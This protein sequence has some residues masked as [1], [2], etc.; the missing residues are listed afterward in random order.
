MKDVA[1]QGIYRIVYDMVRSDYLITEDEIDFMDSICEE[2]S[3]TSELR[4]SALNMS[5]ADAARE[6]KS[7]SNKQLSQF[8]KQLDQLTLKDGTCYREEALLLMGLAL[9]MDMHDKAEI[10]SVPWG[11]IML[12]NNQVLFVENG[13][14]EDVN[15]YITEHYMHIVN[16][17][18]I[19]GFEFVYVPKVIEQLC[20]TGTNLLEKVVSHLAPRKTKE[21]TDAI[22]SSIQGQTT[23]KVYR[24]LLL[25]KLKFNIDINEPSILIRIGLSFVNGKRMSNYVVVKLEEKAATQIDLL[26]DHFLSMQKSPT[27]TIR[28]NSIT[29]DAFVYNGFYRVLFDLI[30]YRK[31]VRCDLNIYPYNHKNV[32][33]ITTKSTEGEQEVPLEI[34]PKECAFYIFLIYETINYGGFNLTCNTALDIKY[35]D[36]AQKRFEKIYFDLCNRDVAPDITNPEIRRPMLSKIKKAVENHPT[37][38]QKMMFIPELSKNKVLKVHVEKKHINTK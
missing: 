8:M 26:I 4:E 33:S 9:S 6:L 16:S 27:L 28:N 36:A 38:V 15:E 11:E 17:L 23:E 2:Y 14:D 37:L 25:G 21:E 3:I 5:L 1:R 7:L 31:G 18:R 32:L 24:E 29:P 35:M 30:T 12:D 22:I 13:F 10:I 19:G 34:G 20:S